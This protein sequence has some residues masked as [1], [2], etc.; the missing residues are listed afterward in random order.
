MACWEDFVLSE[1]LAT[2]M[3]ARAIEAVSGEAAGEA[4]WRSYETRLN[5]LRVSEPGYLAWPGGCDEI[6]ILEDGLFNDAPYVL[7][8][9]FLRALELRVGRLALDAALAS[10][11]QEHVG[12]AVSFADLLEL[13]AMLTGYDPADCAHDWLRGEGVPVVRVCE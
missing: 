11:Y 2:Y 4:V 7:G 13:V 1:G 8:A 6:D 5:R 9:F 3:A 12:S 10:F